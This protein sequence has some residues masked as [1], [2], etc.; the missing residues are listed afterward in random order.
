MSSSTFSWFSRF[1]IVLGIALAWGTKSM[2]GMPSA[3][4]LSLCVVC[5]IWLIAMPFVKHNPDSL[6]AAGMEV[7][8]RMATTIALCIGLCFAGLWVV[9]V[10]VA[11]AFF[12]TLST[13][14]GSQGA[15]NPL[16]R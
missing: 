4:V 13:I 15:S 3:V 8:V 11:P 10:A 12:G 6:V 1:L 2:I 7:V 16:N 9:R 14:D 5:G